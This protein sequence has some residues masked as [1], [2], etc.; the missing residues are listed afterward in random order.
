MLQNA[1]FIGR[2]NFG[3]FLNSRQLL[4]PAVEIG[5]HQA[6]F[7]NALLTVWRGEKLYCVD[8]WVA[9][10]NDKDPVS[11]RTSEQRK[12]DYDTA[13]SVLRKYGNR[14]TIIASNSDEAVS[15]FQDGS[16]SFVYIDGNH[17]PGFFKLDLHIWWP[18]V[19][20][21]GILAGHDIINDTWGA[22]IQDVLMPFAAEKGRD[23]F[24]VAENNH[25]H[26]WS[27]YLVK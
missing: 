21:G 19:K 22:G 17:D 5:T 7:A 9:G 2:D 16:L 25:E 26:P 13:V 1:P 6:Y 23:I 10:Y 27:F 12:E 8:P 4:G 15:K 14:A 20:A 11:I 24:L 3:R 18:K